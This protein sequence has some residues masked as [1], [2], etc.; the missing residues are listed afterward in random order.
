VRLQLSSPLLALDLET[1]GTSVELDR[2]V[3]LGVVALRPQPDGSVVR[4]A[5]ETL[6]NPGIPIPRE[7][8]KVHGISDADVAE[9]KTFRELS[10]PLAAKLKGCD[11]LG[12]NLARFDL[13]MLDA[14]FRRVGLYGVMVGRIID[15]YRICKRF[16]PHTL[17]HE[18][19]ESLGREP[20]KAHSALADAEDALD[21]FEH[22]HERYADDLPDTVEGLHTLFFETP[23]PGAIDVERKL[24]WRHG[25]ACLNFGKHAGLLLRQTPRSYLAWMA[26]G[27]FDARVKAIAREALAGKFPEPPPEIS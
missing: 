10:E 22:Y 24:V 4:T 14:E 21:L 3:Q 23:E 16:K 7:A 9:A 5:W 8:T 27:D 11:Y 12:Y 6:V 13:R 26:D 17:E 20:R 18:V 15:A 2:I 19:R 25:E 1:T